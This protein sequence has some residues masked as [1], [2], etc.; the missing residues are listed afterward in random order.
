MPRTYRARP[1]DSSPGWTHL[2]PTTQPSIAAIL[3]A[4]ASIPIPCAYTAVCPLVEHLRDAFGALQ[5][6][7][8]T[9]AWLQS[10]PSA[11][12]SNRSLSAQL[13]CELETLTG[14]DLGRVKNSTRDI[15][16]YLLENDEPELLLKKDRRALA[17]FLSL[18]ALT[19]SASST[20]TTP[21]ASLGEIKAVLRSLGYHVDNES[22]CLIHALSWHPLTSLTGFIESHVLTTTCPLAVCSSLAKLFHIAIQQNDDDTYS[23]CDVVVIHRDTMKAACLN[24]HGY[25]MDCCDMPVTMQKL[26]ADKSL[27]PIQLSFIK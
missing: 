5:A 4:I 17:P 23:F 11:A 25:K 9:I 21:T 8:E 22:S 10:R 26:I 20:T 7:S 2:E 1:K 19:A 24:L 3:G 18:P 27:V 14:F 16:E 12:D 15:T 13:S 6:S